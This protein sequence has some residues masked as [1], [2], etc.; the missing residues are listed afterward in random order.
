MH[1]YWGT[2]Y[3]QENAH[4]VSGMFGNFVD[5]HLLKQLPLRSGYREQF[6]D[7][8]TVLCP[9]PANNPVSQV[10]TLLNRTPEF[11]CECSRIWCKRFSYGMSSFWSFSTQHFRHSS[12][13]FQVWFV[14][15]SFFLSSIPWYNYMEVYSFSRWWVFWLFLFLLI[16]N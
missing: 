14:C 15:A 7:H 16:M 1:S 4:V 2:I 6:S 9:F 12:V 8:E 10:T 13:L 11:S 5:R 3:I